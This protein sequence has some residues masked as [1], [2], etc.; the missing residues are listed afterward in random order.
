MK[1][2]PF[3][4]NPRCL[5]HHPRNRSPHWFRSAGSYP[6]LAFGSVR[7]FRCTH[8]GSYFSSQT[9]SIDYFSKRT[10]SYPRL[11]N[12]LITTSSIRDMARDFS[13]SVDVV[14]N[15]LE[16]L[17]RNCIAI[18]QHLQRE[19][20][21]DED[22]A[23]DGFE[24]FTVSQ[25]FPCHV[26]LLVGKDSQ[27][28][29]GFDYVTLR[30][31]GRMTDEQKH[32]R[33]ELER[34]FRA[35]PKG[36]ERSFRSLYLLVSHLICEG[37]RESVSCYTDE[38]SAYERAWRRTFAL[39]G[40]RIQR[41]VKCERINSREVRNRAN[42]LFAVNY[43][44]RQLRKDMAEHVRE[45]V[46]F[47]RNVS[48]AIDRIAIYVVYHNLYKMYREAKG[49]KRTHAEVAGMSGEEVRSLKYGMFSRRAFASHVSLEG[50]YRRMWLKGYQ[51][52]LK[53]RAEYIPKY[54]AA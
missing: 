45:T 30:R 33:E 18:L 47:G 13:V 44:D 8:C 49:D 34:R 42:P 28:V 46:C 23:A 4:P 26:N 19:I 25:F 38:H 14:L 27:V 6:T 41:R 32:R 43:L 54:A 24:S 39:K 40:L 15:K 21:L 20:R 7:R 9:F 22:F 29:F 53:E 36:I 2:P 31:K 51:T 3:C 10:I 1:Y 12:H 16:R 11:F 17:A 5:N 35:D 37:R 50:V 52:P 48:R